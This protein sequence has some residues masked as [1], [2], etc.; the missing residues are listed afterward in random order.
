MYYLIRSAKRDEIEL[1]PDIEAAAAELFQPYL[2]QL[3]LTPDKL[4][5][6]VSL[7]FLRRAQ[8]ARRL[9]VAIAQANPVGF[10]VAKP[11]T[12]SFFIVEIDVLPRYTRC[13]IGSA[14]IRTACDRAR[15]QGFRSVTLTTFRY[16]PWNVPFYQ[17]LGFEVVPAGARSREIQAIVAHEDRYGFK[18][19][20]R[21][22]MRRWVG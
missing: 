21:A 22:V 10:L 14:L 13:G 12:E 16:V 17:A 11:L 8:A 15:L 5:K 1:L 9:W 20:H 7:P 6:I 18:R 2:R 3:E 4:N 19:E